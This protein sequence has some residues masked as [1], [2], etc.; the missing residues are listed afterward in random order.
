LQ[1]GAHLN[2]MVSLVIVEE[3]RNK[4]CCSSSHVQFIR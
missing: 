2:L 4:L 3:T 1:L